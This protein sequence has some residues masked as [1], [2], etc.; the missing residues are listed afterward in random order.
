MALQAHIAELEQ[1]HANLEKM[2]E[3]ELTAPTGD[4]LKISQ[5]KREKLK[6][7]DEIIRLQGQETS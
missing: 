6:L 7:K 4:D 5:L 1:R 3:E 2:I